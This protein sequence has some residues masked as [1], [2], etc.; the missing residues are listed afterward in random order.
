MRRSDVIDP[1]HSIKMV[2][3]LEHACLQKQQ[4]RG[5][6]KLFKVCLQAVF[7]NTID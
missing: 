4:A 2:M 5:E 3:K 6:S 7:M 1:A